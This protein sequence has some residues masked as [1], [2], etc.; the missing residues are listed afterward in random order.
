VTGPGSR[1]LLHA[2]LARL[3]WCMG[4]LLPQQA[5]TNRPG[6]GRGKIFFC[7]QM[8]GM[9]GL[10]RAGCARVP[11]WPAEVAAGGDGSR[12]TPSS[13]SSAFPLLADP[14]RRTR[15]GAGTWPGCPRWR[16]T[17]GVV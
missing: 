3:R 12:T 14:P 1:R 9:K 13:P 6:P 5:V 4:L 15:P 17:G 7:R 2:T 11:T 10:V 8:K 16:R